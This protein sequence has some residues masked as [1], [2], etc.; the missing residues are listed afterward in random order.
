M[1]FSAAEKMFKQDKIREL[2]ES[3]K[4]LRY[5]KLRSLSRKEHLES[6]FTLAGQQ[7]PQKAKEMFRKAYESSSISDDH[8]ERAINN[9]YESERAARLQREPTLVSE[10]YKMQAF[11]WGGLHQNS[12]EK[13]IVDNYV[14]KITDYDTLT[15]RIENELLLSMRGYVLCS[16]YNHWTSIIIED[17]FR[18]HENVVPAVGQV[19]KIDF[20]VKDVPFDL[21]VTYMPEGFFKDCRKN[22]GLKPEL[23]ILKQAARA[24]NLS[25]NP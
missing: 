21:K 12:L 2:G 4:G 18:D 16:W 15:S 19:K 7:K 24:K 10:L 25:E 23:T 1:Q 5:L 22:S 14:K 6:L 17:V 9:I 20:F 13:T 3:E 11:D 8:I